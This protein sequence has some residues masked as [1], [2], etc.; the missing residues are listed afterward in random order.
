MSRACREHPSPHQVSIWDMAERDRR[1]YQSFKKDWS[2]QKQTGIGQAWNET[3]ENHKYS[4]CLSWHVQTSTY[5]FKSKP[6]LHVP[7][8]WSGRQ[9]SSECRYS[10]PLQEQLAA[11]WPQHHAM[12][13]IPTTLSTPMCHWCWCTKFPHPCSITVQKKKRSLGIAG[14]FGHSSMPRIYLLTFIMAFP[15]ERFGKLFEGK[16]KKIWKHFKKVKIKIN[17]W[18]IKNL[19]TQS[20]MFISFGFA[21]HNFFLF[22]GLQHFFFSGQKRMSDSDSSCGAGGTSPTRPFCVCNVHMRNGPLDC[23]PAEQFASKRK[24]PPE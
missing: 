23:T 17:V 12:G 21:V 16:K 14:I 22:P 11:A 20:E 9:F 5:G 6:H 4:S 13:R 3:T 15:F 7:S 1:Q 19:V 2:G 18:K 10:G 24:P 8:I